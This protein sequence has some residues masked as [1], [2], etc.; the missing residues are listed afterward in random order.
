[1]D[2]GKTLHLQIAKPDALRQRQT[3]AKLR[4][5]C[6]VTCFRR[7]KPVVGEGVF[8]NGSLQCQTNLF[9][10]FPSFSIQ[11]N[12]QLGASPSLKFFVGVLVWVNG[13]FGQSNFVVNQPSGHFQWKTRVEMWQLNMFCFFGVQFIAHKQYSMM[14]PFSFFGRLVHSGRSQGGRENKLRCLFA[15]SSHYLRN[16]MRVV[17]KVF[18]HV[19]VLGVW[20]SISWFHDFTPWQKKTNNL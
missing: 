4:Y 14:F 3:F 8:P 18:R 7:N 10:T 13:V 5:F 12:I 11:S 20:D 6:F 16:Q 19:V 2:R 17:V 15:S 9:D 1:M